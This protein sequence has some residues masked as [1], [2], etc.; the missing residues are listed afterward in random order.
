MSTNSDQAVEMFA[1][2]FNCAQAVLACSGKRFG[3]ARATACHVGQAFGGGMCFLD[4]TCG[5]VTGA[6]M[7]IGLKHGKTA[8]DD[9]PKQKAGQL[10]REFAS[11]FI[12]KHGSLRCTE[13]LGCDL[14]K[15]KGV[16]QAR[17][18]GLFQKIC[19]KLVRDA[20]E[21]V[22]ELLESEEKLNS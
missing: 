20:A 11:Q 10:S 17:A 7:V 12:A 16:D 13:L 15:P 5:A 8:K 4:Q 14:S 6:L 19:P 21:I 22:D 3:L 18:L 1:Q 9:A 2:G